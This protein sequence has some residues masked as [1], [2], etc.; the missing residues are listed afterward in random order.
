MCVLP[1]LLY[2]RRCFATI[3]ASKK[4]YY[5]KQEV[6]YLSV[7]QHWAI[8]YQDKLV[9]NIETAICTRKFAEA[10]AKSLFGIYCYT[11]GYGTVFT[12]GGN[13]TEIDGRTTDKP[14]VI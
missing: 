12:H 9:S 11:L 7:A 13:I 8:L 10:V 4:L 1:L 14:G 3:S 6:L 2:Q 5:S